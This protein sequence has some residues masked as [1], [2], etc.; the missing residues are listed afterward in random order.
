M[1]KMRC[2]YKSMLRGDIVKVGQV[3]DLTDEECSMGVVKRFFV[4]VEDSA[5]GSKDP[6]AG[7]VPAESGAKDIVVAGLTRDEAIL[8]LQQAGQRVAFNISD[9]RL[10][11]RFNECFSVGPAAQA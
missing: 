8:K 5:A 2:L 10:A 11:E 4:K 6:A 9:K 3:L 7:S 1:T